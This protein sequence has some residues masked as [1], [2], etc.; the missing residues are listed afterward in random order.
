MLL[1]AWMPL[2]PA[3]RAS[4][5][6]SS[7]PRNHFQFGDVGGIVN[8]VRV[9]ETMRSTRF[10]LMFSSTIQTAVSS[11]IVLLACAVSAHDTN[12]HAS[13][14]E[15]VF[16]ETQQ[17]VRKE[18][19]NVTAHVRL[20]RAAFDWAEFARNDD[21]RAEIAQ[22]GIDAAQV[23]IN[24]EPTNAAAHYWLGMDLGQLARTKTLGALKLVR[25]MESEF[26]RAMNLDERVDY[27]G[28]HRS[29]GMLYR[30]APGWPTS[31]GNRKRARAHL[32]RAVQ[33]H[34]EFP[35][36]QLALLES[37]ELWADRQNFARQMKV[38]EQTLTDAKKKFTGPEWEASWAD[39]SKRLA[40]LKSKSGDVGK[41]TPTKGAK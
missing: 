19:T 10:W 11:G 7:V 28:P 4:N 20:A 37:F 33:L 30:D 35:D 41:P 36:N 13:H 32:D 14:A 1:D 8:A 24:R 9:I 3:L 17:Q 5:A 23:A 38:V 16:T 31:I 22:R 26:E 40:E 29:L 12:S 18:Q 25:E 21:Q 27:A 15:Q 39:W 34:P 2:Q 6:M